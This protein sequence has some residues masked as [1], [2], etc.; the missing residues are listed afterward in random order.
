LSAEGDELHGF[1][2]TMILNAKT[3]EKW[4]TGSIRTAT[5]VALCPRPTLAVKGA[6]LKIASPINGPPPNFNCVSESLSA[7][8]NVELDGC[9]APAEARAMRKKA[10]D[11]R[12]DKVLARVDVA[13]IKEK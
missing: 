1:L 5:A 9:T 6:I 10:R 2:S 13:I 8:G 7:L 3:S 11:K 12:L 4:R